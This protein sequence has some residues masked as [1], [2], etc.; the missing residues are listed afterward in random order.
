MAVT[1][2]VC[3]LYYIITSCEG[4]E[5]V[6]LAIRSFPD[7]EA[8]FTSDSDAGGNNGPRGEGHLHQSH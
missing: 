7:D 2:Q 5:I 4:V 3:F 1:R 8:S 6:V